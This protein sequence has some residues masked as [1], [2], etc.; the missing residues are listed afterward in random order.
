M[1]GQVASSGTPARHSGG[2]RKARKGAAID[3]RVRRIEGRLR[4]RLARMFPQ[5]DVKDLIIDLRP[6]IHELARDG[7]EDHDA[8]F[9]RAQ[10]EPRFRDLAARIGEKLAAMS[11][12]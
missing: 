2:P 4:D 7:L 8:L 1:A 3:K 5:V 12:P 11:R 10:A 9:R 6:L